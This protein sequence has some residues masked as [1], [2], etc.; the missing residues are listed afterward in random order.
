MITATLFE[1]ARVWLRRGALD[2]SLALRRR[3]EH[4]APSCPAAPASSP[5]AAAGPASRRAS[6]DVIDA[7]EEPRRGY[8]AAVPV[9][10][11]RSCRARAAAR[12]RATTWLGDDDLRPR[13]IA[14]VERL[15]ADGDSPLYARS[16]GRRAARGPDPR[17]RG[18][19]PRPD[20]GRPAGHRPRTRL[21][22]GAV[23]V[24]GGARPRMSAAELFGLIVSVLVLAYLL[25]AL[26]RGEK[27]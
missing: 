19:P 16:D 6:A 14:L 22:R 1:P 21:L 25:Y 5:H 2:R 3:P 23:R 4:R 17:A 18:A 26:L 15:L 24:P 20:R 12:P 7:A 8:S 10:G 13:G 9:S 27:L 11:V